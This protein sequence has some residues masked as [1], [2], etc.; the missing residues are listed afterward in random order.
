MI[1]RVF[2]ISCLIPVLVTLLFSSSVWAKSAKSPE[3]TIKRDNY[4]VPHI[5]SDTLKGLY[6]GYGYALA[7]D[8]LYQIEMFRRTYWGRLSEVYGS[9]LLAF[10]Q[11]NRRD[12]LTLA[13]MKRQIKNLNPEV[14][15]VLQSFAAGINA[16][17]EEALATLESRETLLPKEF[18]Y[19]VFDP[20]PWTV[21]DVAA[22]FL[23]VMGFFMDISGE[24]AN[25]DML[26]Y[27]QN[28]YGPEQGQVMFD[29][30]CWGLDPESPTTIVG[31]R[32]PGLRNG[33][34]NK[35]AHLNHSLMQLAL[36]TSPEAQKVR[37]KEIQ[38]RNKLF[39][40]AH[41]YGHP[42]SYAA[43]ISPHKS[44]TKKAMLM[45]G[46]QFEFQ[47]PSALYEF[48]L[49]GAG[50]DCVGSTL[51]GYPFIMFG[52]NR[53]AAFSSTAGADNIEDIFVEKLNPANSRQ[54][55]YKGKWRNMVVRS[56]TFAV[57][58]ESDPVVED[59]LYTVHGPVFYIDE[60]EGVAFTKKLSC[61]DRFLQGLASFYYLMK[62]ETVT[63][64]NKAAMLSDMSI[65]YLF[66]N[67][68]GDI[69]YYHLGLH[70]V[71]AKGVDVRL[72]TPGTG[73]FE[74]RSFIPKNQNPHQAN[75]KNGYFVNW[76]NQPE[77]GWGHGDMA[78]TDVWGGWGADSRVTNLI[79]L[80]EGQSVLDRTDLKD[81]IKTIAFYDKRALNIKELL[82]EA[83]EGVSP[84]S[85]EAIDALQLLTEW[86]NQNIDEGGDGFC[87]HPGSAIFDKWWYKAVV[88]TFEPW[89]P[90]YQNSAG[91]AAVDILVNRYLGYTLFYRALNGT[92]GHD[93][94]DGKKEEILYGAL[95]EALDEVSGPL[96]MPMYGY[97]P[98]TVLGFFLY[99]PI[100]STLEP[101]RYFPYVDRGTENHI[102]TLLPKGIFGENITS[103]GNSGFIAPDGVISP[104]F[105][106]QVDMFLEF[107]YKP[108]LFS[109]GQV[110]PVVES[111]KVVKWN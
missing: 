21:E 100:T 34:K 70:P 58:G 9:D 91:Q 8:R 72:P 109:K 51:A 78:T 53:R 105:Y 12:N 99:Q 38:E 68:D 59:F 94:F 43:V 3:A 20:E 108:M 19:F 75:P 39:A 26:R 29:D 24:L 22:D 33:P 85:P 13:E 5:Y 15:T 55:W 46:P 25:A 74:W 52:F 80:V 44:A 27:L 14:R 103:P 67:V 101:P 54:Y 7:Q 104:H 16:Y 47:L 92:S 87:D 30:W 49:H 90:G 48:G 2:K 57:S 32:K 102:V 96:P 107:T 18:H 37:T 88:A 111:V 84:K 28:E 17:I 50:I 76:N 11:S 23:S 6:F 31:K 86:N 79:Q 60:T 97:F 89:Y 56:E 71:R 62:A 63:E 41:P 81:I 93:Y 1:K 98:V 4:G 82:I 35:K 42:A 77:P 95:L 73:E 65:N 61:R 83:V 45:G 36:K 66:A 106:D 40:S 110:N 69:A 10:D 64:F